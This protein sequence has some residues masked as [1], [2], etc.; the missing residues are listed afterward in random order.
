MRIYFWLGRWLVSGFF[1]VWSIDHCLRWP[2]KWEAIWH[3]H[4]HT[5]TWW[6]GSATH[7]RRTNLMNFSIVWVIIRHI[8]L[9]WYRALIV[10]PPIDFYC[11]QSPWFKSSRKKLIEPNCRAIDDITSLV[12]RRNGLT[13]MQLV[14]TTHCVVYT[15]PVEPTQAGD[16]LPNSRDAV[17][18]PLANRIP[19][20]FM[21]N[22][23]RSSN[24]YSVPVH[25]SLEIR[26]QKPCL[27]SP[28]STVD[29]HE[30]L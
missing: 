16:R 4:I 5:S 6:N 2:S 30:I 28:Q 29:R 10:V 8:P 13:F 15:N 26:S 12:V 23:L 24:L 27:P 25:R 21:S 7:Q 17:D 18:C 14:C 1:C 20:Y 3:A 9:K 22:I 11:L 19:R